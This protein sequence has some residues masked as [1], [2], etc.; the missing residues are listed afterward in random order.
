MGSYHQDHPP[1]HLMFNAPDLLLST[2]VYYDRS[3]SNKHTHLSA[4]NM[5]T[6]KRDSRALSL[7]L[8][9]MCDEGLRW[10]H[11]TNSW[12]S[13]IIQTFHGAVFAPMRGSPLKWKMPPC[14]G[15]LF[16]LSLS[17][18]SALLWLE[19]SP[20][21]TS[22]PGKMQL[23]APLGA[24]TLHHTALSTR[25]DRSWWWQEDIHVQKWHELRIRLKFK[26]GSKIQHRKLRMKF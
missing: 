7:I 13:G 11:K 10:C 23:F 9:S 12:H 24:G 2:A 25:T 22:T 6:H 4:H 1:P 19:I 5:H 18:I 21:C 15:N 16:P 14:H 20:W 3:T 17:L 26:F 8:W